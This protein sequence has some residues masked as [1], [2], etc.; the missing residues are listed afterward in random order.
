[1]SVKEARAILGDLI[2]NLTDNEVIELIRS[3][4]LV[5]DEI[6]TIYLNDTSKSK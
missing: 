5:C 1:M 3:V 6:I 2:I 4:G